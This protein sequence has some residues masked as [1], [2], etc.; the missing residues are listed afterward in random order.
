MNTPENPGSPEGGWS[1]DEARRRLIEASMTA[2]ETPLDIEGLKVHIARPHGQLLFGIQFTKV[3]PDVP[4]GLKT[5]IYQ[6]QSV[7]NQLLRSFPDEI[8]LMSA[9][10]GGETYTREDCLE[11][12][13]T[14]R[15][16]EL[17]D[18]AASVQNVPAIQLLVDLKVALQQH[19]IAID[20]HRLLAENIAEEAARSTYPEVEDSDDFDLLQTEASRLFLYQSFLNIFR[21]AVDMNA[22][23]Q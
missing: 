2:G 5:R 11:A 22:D 12:E 13:R 6:L 9:V 16:I 21:D 14:V 20:V 3:S 1:I 15:A 10:T 4:K 18:Q 23:E 7:L 19:D 8:D 17:L